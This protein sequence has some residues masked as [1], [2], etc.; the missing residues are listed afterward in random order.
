MIGSF[1]APDTP[2]LFQYIHLHL[3]G[4]DAWTADQLKTYHN[5][6]FGM[7]AGHPEIEFPGIEVG[8]FLSVR[9]EAINVASASGDHWTSRPRNR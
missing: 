6:D 2:V 4:Y 8:G 3:A 7:A 5:P 9:V 1:L